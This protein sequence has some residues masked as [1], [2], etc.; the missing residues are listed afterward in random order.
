MKLTLTLL[1]ASWL[2]AMSG[3]EKMTFFLSVEF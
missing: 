3:W 2:I 1:T